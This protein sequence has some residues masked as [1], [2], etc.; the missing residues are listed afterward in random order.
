MSDYARLRLLLEVA[1]NASYYNG[2]QHQLEATLTPDEWTVKQVWDA[3]TG[4]A[5][6]SLTNLDSCT[7]FVLEN[8]SATYPV[9]VEWWTQ[10]GTQ[11]N[12][13][14]AGFVIADANPD[15]IVDGNALGTFVTNGAVAGGYVRCAS[16]EDAGNDGTH[17]LQAAAANT[18]TCAAS[19]ALVANAQDTTMTLSFERKNQARISAGGCI[20]IF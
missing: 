8:K 1:E 5:T 7:G 20:A 17:L 6:V 18:L 10:T 16:S 2:E 4:G 12:G 3:P 11:A 19:V 15:T 14:A 13:G 9:L